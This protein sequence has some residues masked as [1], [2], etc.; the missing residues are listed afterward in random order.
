MIYGLWVAMSQVA[1]LGFSQIRENA[2]LEQL[3]TG[4]EMVS[5]PV[6]NVYC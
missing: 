1:P 6:M 5:Y 2:F 3:K 4:Q